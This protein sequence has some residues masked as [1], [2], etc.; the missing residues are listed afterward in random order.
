MPATLKSR[1]PLIAAELRPRT[2]AAVKAGAE[3]IAA[4]ARSK[5]H[6]RSGELQNRITVERRG[7]AE[8]SV[9]AG[10]E[11]AFY[12]HLLEGG[13]D[14]APPYPFLTPAFEENE[15]EVVRLVQASLKTL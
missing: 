8:Y 10:D 9:V 1:L 3:V 12:G 5:V 7:G 4:D 15:G 11:E 13:N 14:I 6:V 2:S